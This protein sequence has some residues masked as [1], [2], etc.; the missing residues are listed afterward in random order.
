MYNI[1]YPIPSLNFFNSLK[2]L[3]SGFYVKVEKIVNSKQNARLIDAHCIDKFILTPKMAP[4][5]IKYSKGPQ[6]HNTKL[7]NRTLFFLKEISVQ[8]ST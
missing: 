3:I 7:M 8:P 2:P 4:N 5:D 6:Q 1:N